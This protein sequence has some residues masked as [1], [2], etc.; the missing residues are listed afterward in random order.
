MSPRFTLKKGNLEMKKI[1]I[2]IADDHPLIRVGIRATLSSEPGLTCVGEAKDGREILPLCTEFHP[3]LLLL[4]LRMPNLVP[5]K[6]VAQLRQQFPSLKILILS[7]FSDEVYIRNAIA[8]GVSGY[9]LKDEMPDILGRAIKG[10]M[11][12][13]LWFSQSV[14]QKLT[15]D[16][17]SNLQTGDAIQLTSREMDVLRLLAVGK[18]DQD[19]GEELCISKSTVR[20]HVQSILEKFE[21]IN[22]TQAVFEASRRGVWPVSTSID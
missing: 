7:A 14:K 21:C 15:Q 10:V 9:I 2:L 8:M 19:I 17:K 1:H 13:D 11:Q 12:G 20:T 4:D 22:R 16:E 18:T 6:A 3:D 5:I